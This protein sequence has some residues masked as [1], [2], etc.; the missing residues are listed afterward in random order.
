MAANSRGGPRR[1]GEEPHQQH[2]AKRGRRHDQAT[3]RP[4]DRM[5]AG[6][7]GGGKGAGRR[8]GESESGMRE[9]G[10]VNSEPPAA[11]PAAPGRCRP[12][13]GAAATGSHHDVW[14][15]RKKEEMQQAGPWGGAVRGT[16]RPTGKDGGSSAAFTS[17]RPGPARQRR[18]RRRRRR[19]R[20]Q[21]WRCR[22]RRRGGRVLGWIWAPP[23]HTLSGPPHN[24]SVGGFLE[25]LS[26]I[27]CCHVV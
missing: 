9:A 27:R 4:L 21:R 15:H 25:T 2:H 17:G 16:G 12:A 7:G 8:G 3:A 5:T 6:T 24:S 23:S 10:Y 13:A 26:Q 18:R 14:R 11:S 20:Q 19:Q 1:C 22:G